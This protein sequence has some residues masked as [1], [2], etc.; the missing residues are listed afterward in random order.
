M[1]QGFMQMQMTIAATGEAYGDLT[2]SVE[3][4]SGAA[5]ARGAS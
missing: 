4:L 2:N 5:R 3:R 1:V